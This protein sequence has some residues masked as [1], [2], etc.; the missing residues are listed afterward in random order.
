MVTDVQWPELVALARFNQQ[1]LEAD[2]GYEEALRQ[3]VRDN[4]RPPKD[5]RLSEPDR[6]R[7]R[8]RLTTPIWAAEVLGDHIDRAVEVIRANESGAS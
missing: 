1:Q 6:A 4:T 5:T 2:C 7:H 8:D 3:A